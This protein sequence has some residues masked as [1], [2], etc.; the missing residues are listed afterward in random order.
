MV[1]A[2][3]INVFSLLIGECNPVAIANALLC[4]F[5]LL[6]TLYMKYMVEIL[7]VYAWVCVWLSGWL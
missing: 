7:F 4:M 3:V 1:Y 2:L 6:C 5:N